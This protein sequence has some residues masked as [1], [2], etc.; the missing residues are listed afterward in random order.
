M[1]EVPAWDDR[2]L[3]RRSLS[4]LC[5]DGTVIY[6]VLVHQYHVPPASMPIPKSVLDL[7][8]NIGAT[9]AHYESMWP[10]AQIVAVEPDPG[11]AEVLRVNTNE[12]VIEAAVADFTGKM[13]LV[14]TTNSQSL[15]P[16]R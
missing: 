8:A 4:P 9:T 6:D 2:T 3:I 16:R 7:G 13:N 15:L 12:K 14:T 11:N 5:S 1:I 10:D